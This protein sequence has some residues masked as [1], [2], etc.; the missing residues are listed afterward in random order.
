VISRIHPYVPRAFGDRL[1][2]ARQGR[3]RDEDRAREHERKQQHE[4]GRLSGL[5]THTRPVLE[6]LWYLFSPGRRP[7]PSRRFSTCSGSLYRRRSA[8]ERE[9]GSIF[10]P[11]FWQRAATEMRSQSSFDPSIT[12]LRSRIGVPSIASSAVTA[13]LWAGQWR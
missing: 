7:R 12:A 13:R 1:Q 11:R 2:P 3:D 10:R 8:V 5:G 9:F 6:N 4:P